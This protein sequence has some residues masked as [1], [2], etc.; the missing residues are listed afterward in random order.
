MPRLSV[1]ALL[2]L[3][4]IAERMDAQRG[5]GRGAAAPAPLKFQFLGP[6]SGG[7]F[8]SI[9]GVVGDT[10]VWYLG[11]A[12]GGVWK[13]VD[14]G[15]T[16]VPVFDK[17]PV[18]AIGSLATS[19]SDPNTVWAGTGEAWAIRDADVVGDGIYKSTDAGATWTNMGLRETGRIGRILV[20]P[21]NPNIVFACAL[22]RATGPQQERGVYRTTDGGQSWTRVLFV[23]PNTGCS[24]I[25]L[26]G[27]DP[28]TIIAGM[29]SLVMHTYKIESGGSGSGVHISHDGGATWTRAGNG[30][31]KS[32]VGKVGVAIAPSNPKRMYALIE[33]DR[34]G[35]MWRT[36]DGGEHWGVVSFARPLIGR[37][38]YYTHV[39]VSPANPDEVLVAE[40]SFWRSID[41]GKTFSTVNWGGDNHDIWWDPTNADHIGVTNDLNGRMTSTHGRLWQQTALPIA[42]AYHVAIDNQTPYW[43]YTNRQDNSTMRGSS[44]GPETPP[45]IGRGTG[46][47]APS[48]YGLSFP[49]PGGRGTGGGQN[50][51]L[52][53]APVAG[54]G[55][56]DSAARVIARPDSGGRGGGRGAVADS[57]AS[58]SARGGAF[59]G[60]LPFTTWDHA[61]GGC[62]SGFTL[63]D[64][65]NTDIVWA[66][67]Y[68]NTVTRWDAKSGV[69]RSVSPWMHTLDWPPDQLKY[70]CHWT[71]P[72]AIDPF[73]HTTVYYG[74]QVMFKTSNGG[75][76]WSVISPDL[77]TRDPSRIVSSGGLIPDNLGQ[78]YGEVVFAIAP[79][80]IQRGLI[81]AGT[82]DGNVWFTR[83]AGTTWNDVTKSMQ[84]PAWGTIRKIEP[85]H[86]DPATAYV[87]VDY[88][89][90]DDRHPVV[91]KT[92]DFGKTWRNVTGDLP[93]AHPLDYV[94]AVTENPN[95]KGMLFTGTG[96]GFFYSMDDG[97]HWTQFSD[98]LPAAPVSWVVVSKLYHDVV[99]STYG[100]GIYV[101]RDISTLEQADPTAATEPLHF[102][103]PRSAVREP[104]GGRADLAF[105]RKDA[106]R[107]S[108]VIDISEVGGKVIRTVK[109]MARPGMNRATWD[110]RYDSPTRVELRTLPPD[111][112]H[113]W[114]EPRFRN[115]TGGRGGG[116]ANADPAAAAVPPT[117]TADSTAR[118]TKPLT[119]PITHW[120][121]DAP[122]RAGPLA[123]P[124]TYSVTIKS[125]GHAARQA[126]QVVRGSSLVAT[127][128]DLRASTAAQIRIRN[129]MNDAGDMTNKLEIMRKQIEDHLVADSTNAA[130]APLRDLDKKLMDVELRILSRSDLNTDDKWYVEPTKLYLTL[131]WLSGEI[132]TGAG[133]VA[134]GADFRPTEA[135]MATLASVEKELA[136]TKAAYAKLM[137]EVTKFNTTMAGKVAP[138]SDKLSK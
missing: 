64:L 13:S 58:S 2:G 15:E 57:N 134:G 43:V 21:T 70:R 33:T 76:K 35:S 123:A 28:N 48:F 9:A 119:R 113:I 75:Q 23:D 95:R 5:G 55:A 121:I 98:G 110:L 60:G 3:S 18:Q 38:G 16:F 103:A 91:M 54:K 25:S 126:L 97:N 27:K 93:S 92:T 137:T 127:D 19:P 31:P 85:S 73:D 89:M 6:A 32:P 8:A 51:G 42:Q 129:A 122:I 112:P 46:G 72:L 44:A 94:M 56:A 11:A 69:A 125:D 109:T 7:R 34:Q 39:M 135:S 52:P 67:C 130:T 132:G 59:T 49:G 83:D 82:N 106:P 78:F 53:T 102:Y 86:F 87:A 81:W 1:L 118:T 47:A 115:P 41:G 68:G 99:V 20:H 45:N 30:L 36:D 124:G 63:P 88:H 12:S 65:I 101:L 17:Q 37:A 100:R 14:S 66:S 29:W 71:P 62:E 61:I 128:G 114:D 107:D 40:S 74:C 4:L 80:E 96:H 120:G 104:R 77:S 111:N 133:D 117:A 79:S 84:L 131:I 138:I 90:M 10:K 22:G 24:S 116:G 26:D 108:V 50:A 105:S 136:A